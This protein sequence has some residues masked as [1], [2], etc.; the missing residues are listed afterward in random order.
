V[1]NYVIENPSN[2]GNYVIADI[3]ARIRPQDPSSEAMIT[4]TARLR[5]R[6]RRRKV[7][8]RL[9]LFV[10]VVVQMD[11]MFGRRWNPNRYSRSSGP[12]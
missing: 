1:G 7:Y 4:A 5:A 9:V 8:S 12:Q 3:Q 6:G 10:V 11:V 2:L